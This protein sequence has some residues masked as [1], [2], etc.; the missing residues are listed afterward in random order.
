MNQR[1]WKYPI[2]RLTDEFTLRLPEGARILTVQMQYGRPCLWAQVDSTA[3][4]TTRTFRIVGTGHPVPDGCLLH[5]L[6]TFQMDG[7]TLVFHLYESLEY[8]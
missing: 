7:G 8:T 6:G 4:L 5:Y 1:V 2:E 3:P